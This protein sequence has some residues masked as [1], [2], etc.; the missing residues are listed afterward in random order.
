MTR[1]DIVRLAR[2]HWPLPGERTGGDG[3]NRA[4]YLERVMTPAREMIDRKFGPLADDEDLNEIAATHMAVMLETAIFAW[5]TEKATV[6]ELVNNYGGDGA[7]PTVIE[8]IQFWER[9]G[10][11]EIE[12]HVNDTN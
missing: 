11:I 7:E 8:A 3:R 4:P 10:Y 6:G 12:P 9:Y 5:G 2:Q 1:E